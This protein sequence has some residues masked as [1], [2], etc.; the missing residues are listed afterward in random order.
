LVEADGSEPSSIVLTREVSSA[1]TSGDWPRLRRLYHD[2]AILTP[3]AAFDELLTPDE[4]IEVFKRLEQDP[5]YELGEMSTVALDEQAAMVSGRLRFRLSSGGFGD[6]FRAWVLTFKDGL[7]Y[8]T[9]AYL[10]ED[11]AR[12]AY[13]EL[14]LGLG[15]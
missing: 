10:S 3:V 6:G 14:G 2:E 15:V 1:F 7:V 11:E 12:T 8:R 13:A 4:I 5:F 9:R